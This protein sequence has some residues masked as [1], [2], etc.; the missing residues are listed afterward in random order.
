MYQ[1]NC[2]RWRA[3]VLLSH[4]AMATW[5]LGEQK[6]EKTWWRRLILRKYIDRSAISLWVSFGSLVSRFLLA[7]DP[8]ALISWC[9]KGMTS[10][11]VGLTEGVPPTLPTRASWWKEGGIHTVPNYKHISTRDAYI[12]PCDLWPTHRKEN[13]AGKIAEP[14]K[15]SSDIANTCKMYQWHRVSSRPHY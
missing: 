4:R 10:P 3:R 14:L 2:W 6:N 5:Y 13:T 8:T 15:P 12:L 1:E 9:R 7:R 11:D